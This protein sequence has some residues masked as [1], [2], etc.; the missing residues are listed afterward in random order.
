MNDEIKNYPGNSNEK[1]GKNVEK[2]IAGEAKR[3][4]RPVGNR[5]KDIFLSE[6]AGSVGGYILAD[7]FIPAIKSML[8]DGANQALERMF[9]GGSAPRANQGRGKTSYTSYNRMHKPERSRGMTDR[10]RAIHDF[11]EV[12]LDS[13]G[14]AEMVLDSLADL[15]AEYDVAT[16]ADFYDLSGISSTPQDTKWGWETLRGSEVRRVSEGYLIRLPKPIYLD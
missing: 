9:F 5:L 3:R 4:K 15:V 12:I 1:K 13:R 2:V 6:D 14:E 10:G 7:V 8:M 11:D 16:V